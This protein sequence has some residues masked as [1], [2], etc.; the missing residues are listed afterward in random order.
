MYR[1]LWSWI[2]CVVVTVVVSLVTK[3]KPIG[4]RRAGL[5][6]TDIP[7]EGHLPGL[8]AAVVL[9]GGGGRGLRDYADHL[10]V[11]CHATEKD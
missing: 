7:S 10:L 1:A 11:G 3:P 4:T 9:G 2:V 5:R 8:P 6:R